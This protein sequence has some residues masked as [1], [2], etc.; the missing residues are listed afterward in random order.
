MP[1][2]P[3]W[4]LSGTQHSPSVEKPLSTFYSVDCSQMRMCLRGP[5]EQCSVFPP[6]QRR[7]LR[8]ERA[9]LP[10]QRVMCRAL[11]AFVLLLRSA[12]A[13][14]G[15]DRNGPKRSGGNPA[16]SAGTVPGSVQARIVGGAPVTPFEHNWVLQWR[17]G[18]YSCGASLIDEQWAMTAAHCTQGNAASS[19]EVCSPHAN[20]PHLRSWL[21]LGAR[22]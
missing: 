8:Q 18:G 15:F 16:V 22:P 11:L 14:P 7:R 5:A 21:P 13:E 9:Y 12:S 19:M 10:H 1:L 4:R 2:A 3:Q 20:T 6:P 17:G